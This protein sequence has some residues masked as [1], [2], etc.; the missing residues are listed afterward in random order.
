MGGLLHL[1]I[2]IAGLA[3]RQSA[4]RI[5]GAS[6]IFAA[7]M[8]FL[9]TGLLGFVIA[10]FLFLAQLTSPVIASLICGASGVVTG[11]I[12]LLFARDRARHARLVLGDQAL[13]DLQAELMSL[14]KSATTA[15]ILTP[16][17]L[18]ALAAFLLT[19]RR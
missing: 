3:L 10:A 17:A 9:L 16:L 12:L 1:G 7:A 15:Q 5:T 2:R 19:S 8:F 18:T 11:A 4:T 13:Q 14:G 6:I